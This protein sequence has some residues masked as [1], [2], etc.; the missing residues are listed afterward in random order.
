MHLAVEGDDDLLPNYAFLPDGKELVVT[1]DG[2]MHRVSIET[3]EATTY[4][5]ESLQ[6]RGTLFVSPM[7][8]IYMGMI[9]GENAR[10]EDL[11]CNPTK[12]KHLTNYRSSTREVDVG[13]KTPLRLSLDAALEWIAD[14]E[15]V[16]V[17]PGSIRLRKAILDE[18]QRK[19]A[20]KRLA[21]ALT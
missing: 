9:V 15:L 5:L 19:R 6:S 4:S 8:A 2:K 1:F 20:G 21:A 17:T 13:L 14:D 10:T 11:P 3:G 16:E 7:D 18:E 12:K